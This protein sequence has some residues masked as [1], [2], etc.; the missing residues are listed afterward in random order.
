[1]ADKEM[2]EEA[3]T[4]KP[5]NANTSIYDVI[6]NNSLSFDQKKIR[7]CKKN[8]ARVYKYSFF[9]RSCKKIV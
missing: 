6:K 2:S 9:K 5:D 1:M 8:L 3:K 4:I 7:D